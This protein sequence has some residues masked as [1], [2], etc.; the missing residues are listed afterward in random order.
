M[1][2]LLLSSIFLITA[3]SPLGN[4]APAS[5]QDE[6]DVL[7]DKLTQD[8]PVKKAEHADRVTPRAVVDSIPVESEIK[9]VEPELS[10]EVAKAFAPVTTG[11]TTGATDEIPAPSQEPDGL[12]ETTIY[13]I[14]TIEVKK[15]GAKEFENMRITIPVY[16]RSRSI[17]WGQEDIRKGLALQQRIREYTEKL[18]TLKK[19]GE[20]LLD[21]YNR[22]I[23]LGIPQEA[24]QSDSPSL[25]EGERKEAS[26]PQLRASDLT[27]KIKENE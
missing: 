15:E 11:A 9:E 20:L 10:K 19:E 1:K 26:K 14:Q 27:I 17:A 6:L 18:E 25:P 23:L 24:L 22:L 13:Q 7:L 8:P 16:Y 2:Y 4:V 5:A 21:E 3:L 12:E